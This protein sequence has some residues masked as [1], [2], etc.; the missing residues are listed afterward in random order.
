MARGE[1]RGG[2]G[3]DK[4]PPPKDKKIQFLNG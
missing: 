2:G 4:A 3:L 1:Q